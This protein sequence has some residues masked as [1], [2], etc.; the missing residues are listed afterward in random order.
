MTTAPYG[1]EFTPELEEGFLRRLTG[2]I[3]KRG[4]MARGNARREALD[5][6]LEGD[7]WESSKVGLEE[8]DTREQ[9]GN[10]EADFAYNLAGLRRDERLQ[11]QQRKYQVED[12]DFAAGEAQKER[13]FNERMTRFGYGLYGDRMR[14]QNRYDA[15]ASLWNTGARLG[16]LGIA[17]GFSLI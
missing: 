12:R 9:I 13:D 10:T 8:M 17:K 4:D 2:G 11:G 16:G 5:R 14:T 15:Q 6:G 1:Q 3:Q 7:V